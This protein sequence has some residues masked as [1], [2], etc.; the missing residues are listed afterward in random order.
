MA[1]KNYKDTRKQNIR[2]KKIYPCLGS[3]FII[4][5]QNC[6]DGQF[7]CPDLES[8]CNFKSRFSFMLPKLCSLVCLTYLISTTPALHISIKLNKTDI[9]SMFRSVATFSII[10]T[11][12]VHNIFI[13]Y[14]IQNFKSVAPTIR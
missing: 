13:M 10:N 3:K 12:P 7:L 1:N 9:T 4:G 8:V 11:C 2:V 6:R 14:L 5:T